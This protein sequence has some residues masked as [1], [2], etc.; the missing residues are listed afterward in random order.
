MAR[1]RKRALLYYVF[2][3]TRLVW[4]HPANRGQRIRAVARAFGYQL[5][6]RTVSEPME[7]TLPGGVKMLCHPDN[8]VASQLWYFGPY[9]E[10]DELKFM[11]RYLRPGDGVI[12]GGANIG[13]YSFLAAPIVGGSGRV[14][15]FE[16]GAVASSRF[17]EN[18]SMN[19]LPQVHLHRA[20]VSERSGPVSFSTE[21]DVS[22]RMVEGRTD[23]AALETV[24]AV[25]L[26]DALPDRRY[27]Y[28][29]LDVEGAEHLALL[30]ARRRLLAHDPPVWQ[31]EVLGSQLAKM[32]ASVDDLIELLRGSGYVLGTYDADSNTL[33]RIGSPSAEKNIL[34]VAEDQWEAVAARLS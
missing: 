15:A 19:D 26:D 25:A 21:W 10:Y 6:K 14:D 8:T 23:S 28:A 4:N 9:T 18:L 7:F 27:A 29:K 32:G 17:A 13:L 3:V 33:R 16:P 2:A 22:N 24:E 12:D 34:A 5:R 31:L 30:G 11:T 20:A 1:R